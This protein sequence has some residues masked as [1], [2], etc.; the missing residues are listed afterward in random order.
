MTRD[1]LI[2]DIAEHL[3]YAPAPPSGTVHFYSSNN[4][5][6][7]LI[8]SIV[9][10]LNSTY[11]TNEKFVEQVITILEKHHKLN[12]SSRVEDVIK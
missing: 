7:D 12:F 11:T 10:Y 5:V 2:K 3:P 8:N 6:M 9:L 4:D 1:Q